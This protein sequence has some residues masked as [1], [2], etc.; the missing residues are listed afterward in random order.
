MSSV[1]QLHLNLEDSGCFGFFV[2]NECT[3]VQ[4]FPVHIYISAFLF[5]GK[6]SSKL[7]SMVEFTKKFLR[8]SDLCRVTPRVMAL[9]ITPLLHLL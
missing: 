9:I 1:E 3:C 7:G 8:S 4:H 5:V 6:V 2:L